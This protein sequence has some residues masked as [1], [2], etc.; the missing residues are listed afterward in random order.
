M[1]SFLGG[2]RGGGG[3][4]LVLPLR[5]RNIGVRAGRARGAGAP[6]NFGQLRFFGRHEK[7]WA[8]PVFKDV[9]MFLLFF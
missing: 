8:K 5:E 9:C 7:I 2:G 1:F 6:P 4:R 3:W